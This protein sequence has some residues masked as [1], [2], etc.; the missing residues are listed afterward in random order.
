MYENNNLTAEKGEEIVAWCD[1]KN[2]N[3]K[4]N[5][6]QI[7]DMSPST[8]YEMGPKSQ[9]TQQMDVE[10]DHFE[11]ILTNTKQVW[12]CFIQWRL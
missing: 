12:M 8:V 9:R 4:E 5:D 7:S 10:F 6:I 1:D 2:Q 11:Q 3:H